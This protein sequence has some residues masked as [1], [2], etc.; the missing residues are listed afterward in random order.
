[1]RSQPSSPSAKGALRLLPSNRIL[2]PPPTRAVAPAGRP[3]P[4]L[5]TAA[6]VDLQD[7]AVVLAKFVSVHA[8]ARGRPTLGAQLAILALALASRGSARTQAVGVGAHLLLL[9]ALWAWS[10]SS[11]T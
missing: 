6:P 3:L 8:L 9:A 7:A 1:M 5:L 11:S 2:L 4:H 10:L